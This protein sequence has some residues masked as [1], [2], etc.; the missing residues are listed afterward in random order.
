MRKLALALAGLFAMSGPA[1][2]QS[3]YVQGL[4]GSTIA[5]AKA[6]DGAGSVTISADGLT[7]GFGGG[8]DLRYRRGVVG[9]L[10]RYEFS[11]VSAQVWDGKLG[12]GNSWL[13]GARAGFLVNPHVLVYG[14]AGVTGTELKLDATNIDKRGLT[15]GAGIE[16]DLTHHLSLTA[17]Y[18]HTGLGK[19]QTDGAQIDA[20]AHSIRLGL[21]WRFIGDIYGAK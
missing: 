14:L 1:L 19:L 3:C 20:D 17:E 18:N 8:C 21:M 11:D 12:L 15:L 10:G 2:A 16:I 5:G 4:A 6:A 9:L 13:L 7:V